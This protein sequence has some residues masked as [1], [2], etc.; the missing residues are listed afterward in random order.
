MESK[1][2]SRAIPLEVLESSSDPCFAVNEAL[3]ITYCNP[4]WDAFALK[5]EGEPEVLRAKIVSR[6]LLAFV[7]EDLKEFHAVLF[8][9]ARATGQ[10]VSHDYECSSATMFRLYRM[11]IYPLDQGFAVIN[12]LRLEHPHDRTPLQPNDAVYRNKGGLI[13]M[14][15]NCRRTNRTSDP[16]AWD[17]VPAYVDRER[18]NVTHGVCPLCLEYYYRPYTRP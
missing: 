14:C 7:P 10:P 13:R 18:E 16:A 11:Q 2:I 4:A 8:A 1:V 5:N 3:D 9:K 15:A 6:N 17:W 12:S